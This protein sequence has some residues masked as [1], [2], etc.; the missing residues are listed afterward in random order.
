V[1]RDK[2]LREYFEGLWW[3][4]PD[5]DYKDDTSDFTPVDWEYVRYKEQ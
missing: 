3:Y 1:F 4:M 2:R 5:P